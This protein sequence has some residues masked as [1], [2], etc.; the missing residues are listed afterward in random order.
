MSLWACLVE[1]GQGNARLFLDHCAALARRENWGGGVAA[2]L[3]K[4]GLLSGSVDQLAADP[5]PKAAV[6]FYRA[7]A[8]SGQTAAITALCAA[9]EDEGLAAVPI[10]V[11]SLRDADRKS[12]V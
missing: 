3:P 7:L 2:P 12:V 8:Q 4:A 11:P 1:G 9:L 6:L 5:R 10:F